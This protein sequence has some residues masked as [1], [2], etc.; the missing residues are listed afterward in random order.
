MVL[1]SPTAF[2]EREVLKCLAGV[3]EVL[4]SE[5]S[6]L[7]ASSIALWT[8]ARE[9]FVVVRMGETEDGPVIWRLRAERGVLLEASLLKER[10]EVALEAAM[11]NG[12]IECVG[13]ETR[14]VEFEMR[15]I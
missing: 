8:F 9:G 3:E 10:R 15:S 6:L 5:G 12:E 2:K 11:F 14:S 4:G 1:V 7:R 13:R